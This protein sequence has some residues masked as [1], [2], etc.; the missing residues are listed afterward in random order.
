MD[1]YEVIPSIRNKP[2][3]NVH[4]FIMIKDKIEIIHT[5]CTVKREI[6]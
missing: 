6:C 5:I 3:I 1:I 2:K 4:G